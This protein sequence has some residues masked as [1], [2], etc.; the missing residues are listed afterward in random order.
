M[1]DRLNE[2]NRRAARNASN[3]LSKLI[4]KL[5]KVEIADSSVKSVQNLSMVIPP[6]EI[7]AGIY[8]SVTGDVKG[9]SILIFPEASAFTLSD[10]LLKR[11]IGTTRRLTELD[12]SALMEVGNIVSGNYLT[13]LSDALGVKTIEH[14][15]RFSM[16]MFGAI[17]GQIIANF[18]EQA[19]KVL[20]VEI[21]FTFE[22]T[23]LKGY[24]F[25]L[26]RVEEL[27]AI[28]GAGRNFEVKGT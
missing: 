18:T 27:Q 28:L 4:D 9:A 19:D 20:V 25:L 14:V 24:F 22:P 6:E 11:K 17:M 7:V 2:I 16:D 10:L 8:L 12:K 13:V 5:V 15:P 3:A 26:F 23:R 1:N 21:E